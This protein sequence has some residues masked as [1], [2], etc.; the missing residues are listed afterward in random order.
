MIYQ[1]WIQA[2]TNDG[3]YT[4]SISKVT[5]KELKRLEPIFAAIKAF[6][7][8]KGKSETG[9]EFSHHNNWPNGE[10]YPRTDLGEKTPEEIYAGILTPEQVELFNDLCP[11]GE[12]GI[13]SIVD[14]KVMEVT[15]EKVYLQR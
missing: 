1:L 7:P 4:S 10:Y 12:S 2:D 5:K 14:I 3:D 13:H 9:T 11:W 6:R 15:K 8:Y